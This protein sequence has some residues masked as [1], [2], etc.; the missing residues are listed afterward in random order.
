M[1]E[2]LSPISL[3]RGLRQR[4]LFYFTPSLLM[5]LFGLKRRQ[6]YRL[7]A[8]LKAEDLVAE[9]EKGKYLL[10][11]LEPE[12]V[13]SN[14]LFIASHLVTPAYVSFWSALHFYG[15]IEQVPLTTFVATTKKKRPVAFRDLRFRFVTLKPHK[16]FGYRREIID[17]LPVL[18]ADE[19]KAI[20][21]SLHQPRYAGGVAEVAKALRAALEEVDE[22]TLV[23]YANRM[24]D[25]SLGSRL[26]YLLESLDRPVEGLIRSAGP[27]KLDPGRPRAGP[28]DGRWKV[29]VNVPVTELW[30]AGVG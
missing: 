6:A 4:D 8:R 20:V 30:P 11:G 7:I 1:A 13:L 21:D 12:R 16:F 15:F 18:I 5:D 3:A 2:H 29:V 17:G 10:L 14:P 23:E 28:Y 24:G 19:A 22:S 25:K 26:G 9:V 27:V